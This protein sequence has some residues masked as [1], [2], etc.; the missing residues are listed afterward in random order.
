MAGMNLRTNVEEEGPDMTPVPK[1]TL[2]REK[3]L[4]E[5]KKAL[6]GTDG[7]VGVSMVVIGSFLVVSAI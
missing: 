4:E 6:A 1:M 3:V 5:A 2:A 7:K